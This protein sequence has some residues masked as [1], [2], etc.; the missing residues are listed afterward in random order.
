MET[1]R[2][3]VMQELASLPLRIVFSRLV[4]AAVSPVVQRRYGYRE[5]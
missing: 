4:T 1:E 3:S 2:I 5:K